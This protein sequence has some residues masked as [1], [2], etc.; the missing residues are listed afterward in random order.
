MLSDPS[1]VKEEAPALRNRCLCQGCQGVDLTGG[2]KSV[3]S[4]LFMIL[5][6]KFCSLEEVLYG[7]W[8]MGVFALVSTIRCTSDSNQAET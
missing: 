6:D 2:W 1:A 5:H 7:P 4:M 3:E 8:L